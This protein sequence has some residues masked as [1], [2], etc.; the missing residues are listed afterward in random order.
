MAPGYVQGGHT[1]P[2]SYGVGKAHD[3]EQLAIEGCIMNIECNAC[4]SPSI[5]VELVVFN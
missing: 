1:S 2:K 3:L 4:I 5:V